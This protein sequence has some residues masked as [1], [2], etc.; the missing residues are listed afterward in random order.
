[1]ESIVNLC[2]MFVPYFQFLSDIILSLEP[3]VALH[4]R[5]GSAADTSYPATNKLRYDNRVHQLLWKFLS[6]PN[7][8]NHFNTK[9]N[10]YEIQKFNLYL[11]ETCP[12]IRKRKPSILYKETMTVYCANHTKKHKM[13]L[14]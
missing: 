4:A 12:S 2:N 9:I 14:F 5:S 7:K 11:P 10:L 1:M 3:K 13:Q 6:I 8:I